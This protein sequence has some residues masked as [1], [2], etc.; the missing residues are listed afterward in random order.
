MKCLLMTQYDCFE[1]IKNVKELKM[2]HLNINGLSSKI[3]YV[4]FLLHPTKIDV[5]SVCETKINDTI[6][7]LDLKIDDYVLYRHDWNRSGGGVLF[8]TNYTMGA[9]L[10]ELVNFIKRVRSFLS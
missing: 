9:V 6:T 8:Y 5:F 3:D 1:A 10:I 7:D 4:K 2:A